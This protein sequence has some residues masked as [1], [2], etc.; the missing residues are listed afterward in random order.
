MILIS[1]MML[2]MT[3]CEEDIGEV[4]FTGEEYE[5]IL[6]YIDSNQVKYSSFRR[7]IE[8]GRM[9]D[10]LSSYNSHIGGNGFT[11]FLPDNEAVNQFITDNSLFNTLD[12]LLKDTIYTR[13]L[14]RYHIL[15]VAVLSSDFANGALPDKT[16]SDDFLTIIFNED[17]GGNITFS[18]NNDSRIEE[19]NIEK[20]NGIVHL[21]D[22]MLMPVVYT[23]YEWVQSHK[24]KGYRIF[25]E[26]LEVTGLS[27]TMNYYSVNELGLNIYNEYTLFIESDELFLENDIQTL[28]QLIAII[29]PEDTDYA[30]PNN[31]VN[32]FA[33]YHIVSQSIFLDEFETSLYNTYGDFPISVDFESQDLKFNKG[34]QIFD[35]LIINEDTVGI[36]YLQVDLDHS[37]ITTKT[38]AI[39]QLDHILFPYLPGRKKEI[40]EFYEEYQINI[41]RNTEGN[42]DIRAEELNVIDLFGVDYLTYTKLGIAISGVSNRDYITVNGNFEFTYHM[43]KILAGLYEVSFMANRANNANAILQVYVDGKKQGSIIDLTSGSSNAAGF[44]PEFALGSIEFT[45]YSTHK[46]VIKTL[47]PG[48]M[49]LDRITFDPVDL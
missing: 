45:D 44:V 43:P 39:H 46:I 16:L 17:E 21:I 35:T 19:V 26:L 37:N 23:G 25:S 30:N 7:I 47:V 32:K 13:E 20:S 8:V 27:D 36:D 38:G 2:A 10:V 3:S 49:Q 18:V 29:G 1:G 9:T 22:K 12:E 48:R 11:L 28:D 15:N 5:N 6:Q 40:F 41:L 42:T 34:T 24:D 31:K 4:L 14:V 33:R